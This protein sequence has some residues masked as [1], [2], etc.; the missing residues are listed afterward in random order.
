MKIG[1][2]LINR[3]AGHIDCRYFIYLGTTGDY[4]N[5]I[6]FI[7][8]RPRKV[9]YYIWS[10]D[11]VVPALNKKAFEVVGHTDFLKIAKQDLDNIKQNDEM[12]WKMPED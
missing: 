2:I 12:L 8:A 9:K 10:L 11:K 1:D 6:E 3:W 4:I 7:N 5:G